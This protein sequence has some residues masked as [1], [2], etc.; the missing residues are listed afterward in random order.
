MIVYNYEV[1]KCIICEKEKKGGNG[2]KYLMTADDIAE[3]AGVSKGKII[4]MKCRNRICY[5]LKAEDV[6]CVS[7]D[8]LY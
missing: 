2:M 1:R 6:G 7:G 5:M 3:E 4:L 8:Y